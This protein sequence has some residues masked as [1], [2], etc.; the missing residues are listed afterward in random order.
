[1]NTLDSLYSKEAEDSILSI[2]L[3]DDSKVTNILSNL[4]SFDFYQKTHQFKIGRASCRE[5]V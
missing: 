2:L 4:K 1:M 5:R 3:C